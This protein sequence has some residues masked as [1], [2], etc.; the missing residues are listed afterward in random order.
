MVRMCRALIH[1]RPVRSSLHQTLSPQ[2]GC[3]LAQ[4]WI[5]SFGWRVG[6]PTQMKFR[7]F[8]IKEV[9][10][11]WMISEAAG[12][13]LLDGLPTGR[14]NF[15]SR[16]S[17]VD[18]GRH[19]IPGAARELPCGNGTPEI[20]VCAGISANRRP[21]ILGH[22]WEQ[23]TAKASWNLID[24]ACSTRGQPVPFRPFSPPVMP[25]RP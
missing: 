24:F 19:L 17:L 13:E 14:A 15:A 11:S 2:P 6:S 7:D 23:E 20:F 25:R 22:P 1:L 9:P 16:L 21:G 8:G 4:L 10:S 12:I 5:S 3:L 18:P